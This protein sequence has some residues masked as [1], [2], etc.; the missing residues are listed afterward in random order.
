M[1]F[2]QHD[3]MIQAVTPDGSDQSHP[4]RPLPWTCRRKEDFL[5]AHALD[6][7]VEFVPIDLVPVPQQVTWRRIFGRGFPHLLPCPL[8]RRMLRY[9]EVKDADSLSAE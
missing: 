4:R 3:H 1:A 7:L 2:S 8:S 6:S 5:S 9:V